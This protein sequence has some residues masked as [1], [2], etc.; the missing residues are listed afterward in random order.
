MDGPSRTRARIAPRS[1]DAPD[2]YAGIDVACRVSCR[3][4]NTQSRTAC[5]QTDHGHQRPRRLRHP[6]NVARR[7]RRGARGYP[8]LLGVD[9]AFHPTS[10]GGEALCYWLHDSGYRLAV[11]DAARVRR[12][13]P[14]AGAKTDALDAQ[15]IADYAA[16]FLDELRPW[17]PSEA[18]V[19][20]VRTL[21]TMREQLTRER[22]AKLNA[23]RMLARK[24]VQ[25]PLANRIA[26]E[27]VAYLKDRIT[28]IDREIKRPTSSHP[29]I[30]AAV[31]L[32]VSVPGVGHLL[33]AHLV[34]S[35]NR[36]AWRRAASPG[37]WGRSPASAWLGIC[38][39]EH[40]S[41]SSVRRK[42]RSRG[43]GPSA[44]RK[45]LH[46]ASMRLVSV[47][48]SAHQ[49]YFRTGKW[50]RGRAVGSCSTTF[51]TS[52]SGWRP[53]YSETGDHRPTTCACG[54]RFSYPSP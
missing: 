12:A 18:V 44:I 46:M 49:A 38:P 15:R 6:H 31:A 35:S 10:V 36:T 45:L 2:F 5:D 47:E 43:Y 28:E 16:R 14:V 41:G 27:T 1:M 3:R 40:E 54:L 48:G 25:T 4:P 53:P 26:G 22:T 32:L 21:L 8:R 7:A 51:R 33:A 9:R 24:V 30:G 23:Q 37:L 52:S 34:R 39:L 50:R 19:E 17:T 11:E 20:Q 13:M 29:T 42:P